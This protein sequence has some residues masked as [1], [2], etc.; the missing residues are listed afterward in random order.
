MDIQ[1]LLEKNIQAIEANTKQ[2]EKLEVEYKLTR[3]SDAKNRTFLESLVTK[4]INNQQAQ[5]NKT[6]DTLKTILD[7]SLRI[8]MIGV[9]VALGLKIYIS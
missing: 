4:L 1:E 8:G 9:C 3:K 5:Q 7:W 2:G 6:W